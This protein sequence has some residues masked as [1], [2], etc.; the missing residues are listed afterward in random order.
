MV[1]RIPS[2]RPFAIFYDVQVFQPRPDALGLPVPV[3]MWMNRKSE[4]DILTNPRCQIDQ[5]GPGQLDLGRKIFDANRKN[6]SLEATDA[7]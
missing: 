3:A 7:L 6:E 5:F 1:E 2:V 4:E